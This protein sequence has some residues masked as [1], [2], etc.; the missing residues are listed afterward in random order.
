MSSDEALRQWQ[1]IETA[2]RDA[3][4]LV[5]GKAYGKPYCAVAILEDGIWMQFDPMADDYSVESDGHTHWMPI[6]EFPNE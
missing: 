6:P 3:E 5:C 4:V 1:P 2:P